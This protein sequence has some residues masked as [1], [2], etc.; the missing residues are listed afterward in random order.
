[1]NFHPFIVSHIVVVIIPFFAHADH[2]LLLLLSASG[3]E[4]MFRVLGTFNDCNRQM[5]CKS[6]KIHIRDKSRRLINSLTRT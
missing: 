3:H 4:D 2:G 5:K 1:M 6:C